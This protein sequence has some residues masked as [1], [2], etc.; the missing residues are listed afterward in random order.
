MPK[1]NLI[2]VLLILAAGAAT[3]WWLSTSGLWWW[4]SG[5]DKDASMARY[6]GLAQAER[7]I[8]KN[9]YRKL[10]DAALHQSAVEGMIRSLDEFSTY[11]P[12]EQA[13]EFLR[14]LE[15]VG[16]GVGLRVERTGGKVTVVEVL[17]NSPAAGE[18]LAVGDQIVAVDGKTV[19]SA[20]QQEVRELL[21][22]EVGS[23]VELTIRRPGRLLRTVRLKRKRFPI[24]SVE[25]LYR[26]AEGRWVHLVDRDR[27]LA[28]FRIRELLPH[29]S[30]QFKLAYARVEEPRG[31]ILDLRDNPGGL[32]STGLAVANL[33]LRQ[34]RIATWVD[35]NGRKVPLEARAEGTFPAVPMVVLVNGHSASGA[36]LIAGA[37]KYHDRA[38]IVGTR[39]RG[40]GCVQTVL[41]LGDSLGLV[42]LTTSEFLI[43]DGEC[44]TRRCD[45]KTWGIN[46]H[47]TVEIP[48]ASLRKLKHRYMEGRSFVPRPR[49]RTAAAADAAVRLRQRLARE[50]LTLDTQLAWAVQLLRKGDEMSRI[51]QAAARRR[52]QEALRRDRAR[53][54]GRDKKTRDE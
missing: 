7:I 16:C 8:R 44:I 23:R 54:A 15:G 35:R 25:G 34:G 4:R 3:V 19:V 21:A 41:S 52:E 37:L 48:P 36:E 28:Y 43:G 1:R 47:E 26:N 10:D 14:R 31:V 49:S 18:D 38:V 42:N 46:P 53:K 27:R 32:Q 9:Y 24:E 40:K 5:S 17:A 29:T 50:I 13:D 33:F 6:R 30:E 51:L 20:P 11:V 2:W 39:T 45:S 12:P 22:G